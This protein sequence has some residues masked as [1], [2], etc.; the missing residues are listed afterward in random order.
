MRDSSIGYKPTFD[1]YVRYIATRFGV[2]AFAI[3]PLL[4]LTAARMNVLVWL[5][6]WTHDSWYIFHRWIGRLA[7]VCAIAHA[8]LYSTYHLML[9]QYWVKFAKLYWN[10]GILAISLF[11]LLTVVSVKFFRRLSYEVFLYGHIL[12]SIVFILALFYHSMWERANEWLYLT[13]T[14]WGID[15]LFRL[16]MT[17]GAFYPC[18]GRVLHFGT[19]MRIDVLVPANVSVRPGQFAHLRFPQL[20]YLENHP[21]TTTLSD[22]EWTPLISDCGDSEKLH[23][24]RTQ[25]LTFLIR[26]FDGMTRRLSDHLISSASAINTLDRPTSIKVYFEGPYGNEHDLRPYDSLLFL[27]GGVG[28]TFTLPYLL[29]LSGAY[30]TGKSTF[31][32][33]HFVWVTRALHEI[34]SIVSFLDRIDE[35]LREHVDIFYTGRITSIGILLD[36]AL[37][38][39]HR[40]WVEQVKVGRPE[41]SDLLSLAMRD[42]DDD[43]NDATDGH[44]NDDENQ[45]RDE[46][47]GSKPSSVAF[48]GEIFFPLFPLFVRRTP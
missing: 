45:E 44:D 16:Y 47:L 23:S 6:H 35:N 32:R 3:L 27:A 17:S 36:S 10:C 39:S 25:A 26:P 4:M 12:G 38:P 21:S 2:M 8:V 43:D 9:N 1:Q 14:C 30:A 13:L 34:E 15:R 19:M 31:K 18:T 7:W 24:K 40:H 29:K 22:V 48:L 20:R 41:I 28:I 5:T 33:I 11:T 37:T 46:D 42:H